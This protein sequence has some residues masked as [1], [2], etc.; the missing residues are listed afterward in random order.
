MPSVW[1]WGGPALPLATRAAT[2]GRN[3]TSAHGAAGLVGARL[4][5][6]WDAAGSPQG[7]RTVRLRW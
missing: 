6:V 2:G 1:A 3:G 4:P 5:A 7:G